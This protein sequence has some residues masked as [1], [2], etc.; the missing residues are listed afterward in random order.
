Y[1]RRVRKNAYGHGA[2]IFERTRCAESRRVLAPLYSVY[3]LLQ[4]T[5]YYTPITHIYGL[6]I[7]HS[8]NIHRPCLYNSSPHTDAYLLFLLVLGNIRKCLY[9]RRKIADTYTISR[10]NI[11]NTLVSC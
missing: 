4:K 9:Y 1:L 5:K 7:L 6:P 2:Q 8:R 11:V 3:K 10:S